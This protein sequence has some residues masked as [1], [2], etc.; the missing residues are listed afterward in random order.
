LAKSY[1]KS[2]QQFQTPEKGAVRVSLEDL[3]R[4]GAQKMLAQALEE[5]V[6]AFLGRGRYERGKGFRGYRNGY[7]E[8]RE[9]TV[10]VA[11]VSVRVPRV[12]QIPAEVV[13]SGPR[14]PRNASLPGCI[15][16]GFPPGISNRCFG[17][18]WEKPPLFRHLPSCG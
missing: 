3:V 18:W 16:K 2:R 11:P 9:V 5:E 4:E 1:Q 8:A 6:N 13:I 7:H 14:R 12:S 15:W 17:N 10:G